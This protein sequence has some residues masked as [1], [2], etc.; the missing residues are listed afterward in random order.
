MWPLQNIFE[1]SEEL[2]QSF[3]ELY[4]EIP[5]EAIF[6]DGFE[7]LN[8]RSFEFQRISSTNPSHFVFLYGPNPPFTP[9]SAQIRSLMHKIDSYKIAIL[10]DSIR[11]S[12]SYFL[13]K[14]RKS[15]D[16]V[17]GIDAAIQFGTGNT[18]AVGPM[19]SCISNRTFE[20]L[21]RP[22][23]SVK[24]D[25]DV[26][27][28]GTLYQERLDVVEFLRRHGLKITTM[29]GEYGDA[30]LSFGE[31]L[32]I[33]C[34][35]KIRISTSFT[36][37]KILQ[38]SSSMSQMKGHITEAIASASLLLLDSTYPAGKFFEEGKEFVTYSS[39]E[40]LLYKVRW[41]LEHDDERS[42]IALRAH[43]RWLKNYSGGN[44]WKI[45]FGETS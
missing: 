28:L 11:L 6:Y 32:N 18:I 42:T 34:R 8:N 13:S 36:E 21:I 40:D 26:L 19:T 5:V 35:A 44:F 33:S 9:K 30:R 38:T 29:G 37:K 14:I 20:T 15:F 25:I 43:E 4:P 41:Y 1:T 2:I 24:R 16:A 23:L 22:N 12:H 10:T 7:F 3:K 45:A 17:I 31:Y 27:I 39:L